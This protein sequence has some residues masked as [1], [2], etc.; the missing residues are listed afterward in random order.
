[1]LSTV[2]QEDVPLQMFVFPVNEKA[3][4]DEIF[5]KYLAVP[6]NPVN[7]SPDIVAENRE[8]WIE[9]WTEAVLR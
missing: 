8:K 3:E 4:L 9:A 1:M 5:I 2:F 6:E 7:L